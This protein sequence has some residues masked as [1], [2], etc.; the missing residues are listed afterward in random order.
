MIRILF[1]VLVIQFS[2]AQQTN[3]LK[4][5]AAG[6]LDAIRPEL[7]SISDSIWS[8]SEPSFK[9][10]QTAQLLK[11][12]LR[13]AG[14]KVTPFGAGYGTM[15]MASYG[16][17]GPKVGILS[18]ADA[19]GLLEPM[20]DMPLPNT[21][22]G[23]SAGHHLLATGSL[24]AV[25]ALKSLMDQGKINL[26]LT[27]IHSTAEGSLGGRVPMA[28]AG[29]FD[30]LDLAFYWHPSPVTSANP[31]RWDAIIDMEISFLPDVSMEDAQI[32]FLNHIQ[33]LKKQYGKDVLM[34]FK[35]QH[36]VMDVANANNGLIMHLRIQH[37]KQDQAQEILDR[38]VTTLESEPLRSKVKWKVFRAVREFMPNAVGNKLAYDN[39]MRL[40]K[41][42]VT[43]NDSILAQKIWKRANTQQGRFLLDART[44]NAAIPDGLYGYGSDIGDVS[45]RVPLISFV[46]SC[47]PTGLSMRNWEATAFG[48]SDFGK[49]GMMDASKVMVFTVID[50]LFD[51]T[52]KHKIQSEFESRLHQKRNIKNIEIEP[53]AFSKLKRTQ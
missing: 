30:D 46:V 16:E 18:E 25:L 1:M 29:Y 27:Y 37:A 31:N 21:K 49:G 32:G 12:K 24:G 7:V 14:F 15:F 34:H 11:D 41:R 4:Q 45:W 28:Q 52:A 38:V 43:S 8:L 42:S 33:A 22:Y 10:Y 40:S 3:V 9:E 19:D 6:F 2:N 39:M 51:E 53:T 26:R 36:E 35:L 17:M 20:A 23:Q 44:W 5:E 47:I 13:N 50:Y 48:K